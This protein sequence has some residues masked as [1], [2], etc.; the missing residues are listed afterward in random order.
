MM[1]A[2]RSRPRANSEKLGQHPGM[3]ASTTAIPG[4]ILLTPQPHRDAR[5]FFSRTFDAAVAADAGIDPSAFL[6]DSVSRSAQG[7]VRGLH[8][9]VGAGENKLVRCSSGAIFDVVVD[10]RPGS[11]TYRQ[12]LSF[13][14]D[15][16]TQRSIYVPAGCAHGF[17]ALTAPADTSYRIDR[18]HDPAEDLTIAH[19]DPELAIPWPRPVTLQSAADGSAPPLSELADRLARIEARVG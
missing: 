15:G 12:W 3:H 1:L 18:E 10:L 17:Q 19:D 13:D 9:R 6:Q 11:P 14:L 4:L 5:G 7:V 16:E 8:V 2:Q